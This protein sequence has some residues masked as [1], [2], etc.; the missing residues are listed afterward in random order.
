MAWDNKRERKMSNKGYEDILDLC[1]NEVVRGKSIEDCLND[2][3]EQAE[4]LEPLLRLASAT[5]DLSAA[6]PDP[7]FRARAQQQLRA[8]IYAPQPK[9]NLKSKA[10]PRR[11][12]F[13]ALQ[14]RYVTAILL[15]FIV[16]LGAT[17]GTVMASS[18]AM[19]DDTLYS[20]KMAKERVQMALTFSEAEKASLHAK[21]A[22]IRAEEMAH[23]AQK[24]NTEKVEETG[25]RLI[26]HIESIR[27]WINKQEDGDSE[28]L[29]RL[30]ELLQ[31]NDER[32]QTLFQQTEGQVGPEARETYETGVEQY[33]QQYGET[34]QALVRIRQNLQSNHQSHLSLGGNNAS[35]I[36]PKSPSLARQCEIMPG[37]S[38]CTTLFK[39][40]IA[41]Y[42]TQLS[43]N[44]GAGLES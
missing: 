37:L 30:H 34:L 19:P 9:P 38:G 6:G 11:I 14:L 24:N 33:N 43:K 10:Q 23:M 20:L 36:A 15:V 35:W 18:N 17:S 42:K 25:A 2:H 8:V 39:N 1:L 32:I 4:E 40:T 3:P 21:F 28:R 26:G 31:N 29:H 27:N 5:Y 22:R 12:P 13:L 44:L 16:L 41:L 7:D